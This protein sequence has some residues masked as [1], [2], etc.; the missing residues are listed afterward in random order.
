MS[1]DAIVRASERITPGDWMA[2]AALSSDLYNIR[3]I[4]GGNCERVAT[5]CQPK[6]M[7]QA[8]ALA[9]SRAIVAVPAMLKAL[10]LIEQELSSH[11]D[12]ARGNSKVHFA[13]MQAKNA[14]AL[15]GKL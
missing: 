9:N 2:A 15:A 7:P 10:E 11:P 1:A 12:F 14:L 5:V 8:E 4:S 6:E 13:A 3:Y